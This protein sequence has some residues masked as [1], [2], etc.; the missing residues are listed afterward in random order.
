METILEHIDYLISR[1]EPDASAWTDDD[2]SRSF[3][4]GVEFALE[5]I[6]DLRDM[7]DE[8]IK[9][10]EIEDVFQNKITVH[11]NQLNLL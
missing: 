8:M 6:K 3:A 9:K 4:L 5:E 7:I 2:D 11:E 10:Q 1:L